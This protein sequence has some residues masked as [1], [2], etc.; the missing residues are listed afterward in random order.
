MW[1]RN[2][3]SSSVLIIGK[4]LRLTHLI[5]FSLFRLL[6]FQ[7]PIHIIITY[8]TMRRSS[9]RLR[10]RFIH[11]YLLNLA[12]LCILDSIFNCFFLFLNFFVC[13]FFILCSLLECQF[14]RQWCILG[15]LLLLQLKHHWRREF[16][17]ENRP[18][19]L[20]SGFYL[21]LLHDSLSSCSFC[22]CKL[23][24]IVNWF[25]HRHLKLANFFHFF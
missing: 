1:R 13:F 18:T 7:H 2:L 16:I 8:F 6:I 12:N 20:S 15:V 21:P 3:P 22:Y 5:Y 19:L 4:Y 23:E 14:L 17:F 9:L 11:L 25:D 10:P 24:S